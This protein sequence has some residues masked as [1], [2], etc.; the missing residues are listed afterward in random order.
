VAIGPPR[1]GAPTGTA[2][3]LGARP[4]YYFFDQL[5]FAVDQPFNE[6]AGI[7]PVVAW[8]AAEP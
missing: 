2:G 8:E 3:L 5:F 1:L 6:S 7:D 4:T